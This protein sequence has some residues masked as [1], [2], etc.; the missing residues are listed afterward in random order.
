MDT[1]PNL[2]VPIDF[3]DLSLMAL[4]YGYRI[5]RTFDLDIN[6]LYVHEEPGILAN[7]FTSEET[8]KVIARI[9]EE[10]KSIARKA[11]AESGL[12]VNAIVRKGTVHGR[13]LS[14]AEELDSKMIIMGT[15]SSSEEKGISGAHTSRVIR[16]ANRPVITLT[17][18]HR[19]EGCHS[20]LLPLD[21]SKETRQKVSWAITM[22]KKMGCRIRVV[23][24]LWSKNDP[25]V[26]RQLRNQLNQVKQFIT[27]AGVDCVGEIVESDDNAR[28]LVPIILNYAAKHIDIDMII[29]MT[30]Q[31]NGVVEYF[32]GSSAQEIIR[33]SPVPVMSI[34]PKE[35]G[36]IYFNA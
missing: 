8:D 5:A 19:H 1:R 25:E 28:T 30:Q 33:K 4:E 18:R 17:Q 2:L 15:R 31:E 22:A 23:S 36:F 11:S 13:I 21:L 16:S 7:F 3:H 20:I 35:L 34:V 24:A 6:L 14:M 27:D 29:I 12:T 26:T 10:L 32:L 9:R